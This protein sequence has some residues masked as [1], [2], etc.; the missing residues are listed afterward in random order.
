M[1]GT[2]GGAMALYVAAQAS[3]RGLAGLAPVVCIVP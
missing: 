3:V 1:G 2:V